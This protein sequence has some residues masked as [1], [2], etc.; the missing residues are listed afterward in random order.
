MEFLKRRISLPYLTLIIW[1]GLMPLSSIASAADSKKAPAPGRAM[2]QQ[3]IK[4]RKLWRTTD[5]TKH[6]VL[7]KDFKSG[8]ELTQA[9]ISCHSEAEKQ[10]HQTI[11]WTWLADPSDKDRQY[12]KAGN[13]FNNYC[14]STNKTK[15][16]GCLSCH[17]GWGKSKETPVN[18]LVCHSKTSMNFDEAMTDIQGFL[19]DGDDESKEMAAEIQAELR[20]AAQNIGLPG[21]KNCGSCHFYGGG[22]DGVK[23]GDLDTSLAKPSKTLD[24]HMGT[25]GQNFT[26]TRC[27]TT[28]LH[29]ISGRVYTRPAATD[30]KSLV[31]DDLTT[32]ITCESCHTAQP[33]KSGDKMNQHTDKV[34]CQSC[35]ISEFARVNPT[36][37]SWD[38]SKSG[39][40]KDG[41]KYKTKDEFGKFNYLTIKGQMKWAKNVK[42]E[43]AWYDGVIKSVTAKDKIDPSG[44]VKV[45]WPEGDRENP[46]ARIYP[47][48]VHRGN[49]PYDKV[50][51]TLLMPLLS[52]KKGYWTTL[53]WK[54]ALAIGQKSM[55]LPFSGEF[56]F[57]ET[58]YVFPITHMVAPKDQSLSCTECHSKSDG[59]LAN[60]KGFYMPG[61]DGSKL[62]NVAGW[63]VVLASLVG[64]LIHALG[65]T[66]SRRNGRKKEE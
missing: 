20:D 11:H 32:K 37:M 17:P 59:R 43:Y 8:E 40:L 55:D 36:K 44:V 13:S 56:D 47:F 5:H 58:T 24:V 66:F 29:D 9:C 10:F 27:H 49:Q 60:L 12:G 57:V 21:R 28:T 48:K 51:Q 34:A 61:R 63:G 45:S 14:I 39:K 64:V 30:R 62:L 50:N 46:N 42:P 16:A 26:C 23:H 1:F 52:S 7:Q 22:G 6:A 33:H 4:S 31:E 38:W 18:C 53:D 3:A 15:D 65:R 25:D 2:A 19:A 41:K 54:E 35:H